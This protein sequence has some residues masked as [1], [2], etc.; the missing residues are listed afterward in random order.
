MH[1]WVLID[2]CVLVR[3]VELLKVVRHRTI[4]VERHKLLVA[5]TLVVVLHTHVVCAYVFNHTVILSQHEC[6]GI[7]R[8]ARFHARTNNRRLWTKQ[9]N[10]LALH[11]R[12]HER[13]VRIIVLKEWNQRSS[14]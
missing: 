8:N 6:T 1:D 13:T 7:T 10:A 9:W 4:V 3:A 14:G 5:G 12:T 2:A 11:V